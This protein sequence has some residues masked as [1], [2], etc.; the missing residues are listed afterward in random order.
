LRCTVCGKSFSERAGT[1]LFRSRLPEAKA[2]PIAQ[3]LAD[4]TGMRPTSRRCGVSLNSVLR[5]AGR[6]GTHAEGFHDEWVRHVQV[7]QVP[8]DEAWSFVPGATG[9]V[10][11]QVFPA[12]RA[13]GDA[14]VAADWP[15]T[16]LPVRDEVLKQLETARAAKQIGSSLEAKVTISAPPPTVA[17]LRAYEERGPAFPGN[18]ANLF[19][20]SRAELAESEG[21]L[22]V[23]VARAPGGKCER[24]WTYSENVGRLAHPGVCERCAAVLEAR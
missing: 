10:H 2:V 23:R 3:H 11:E 24:C 18:L 15:D 6:A 14:G 12:R 19:I 13:P 9:S 17:R 20:V 1:P 21:A 22:S 4:G 16:F 8:A 7:R 5:F